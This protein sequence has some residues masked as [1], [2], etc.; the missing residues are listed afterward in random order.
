MVHQSRFARPFVKTKIRLE[1]KL[2]TT[3][4]TKFTKGY[5]AKKS[6]YC[7]VSSARFMVHQSRCDRPF[8]KTKI[9]LEQKLFYHEGHEVHEGLQS[10]KK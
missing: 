9:R 5:R 10:K 8:I 7:L 4:A 3:K 1:Q 2:F 6:Q